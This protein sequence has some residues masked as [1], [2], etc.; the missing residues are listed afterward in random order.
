MLILVIAFR[1]MIDDTECY[2]NLS[3]GGLAIRILAI[4]WWMAK[5]DSN[6]NST[7]LITENQK[8]WKQRKF[9]P[10]QHVNKLLQIGAAEPYMPEVVRN[11][12]PGCRRR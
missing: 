8:K 6:F 4:F 11:A 5:I 2:S 7:V 3:D 10:S 12:R 1:R 9:D